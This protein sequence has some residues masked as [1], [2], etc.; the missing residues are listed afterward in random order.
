MR[1]WSMAWM[2]SGRR[3]MW[4]RFAQGVIL[5]M[6][7][8]VFFQ[9]IEIERF[10]GF[11]DRQRIDLD[12]SVLILWGANGTGKTSFFDALQ[13]LIVGSVERLEPWRL[14]RNAEHIVNRYSADSGEPADVAAG[15]FV[16]G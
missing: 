1:S 14:R 5:K 15:L 11:A 13:W 7:E 2:K 9:W 4:P 16:S 12:A 10:R 6:S 3:S 8:P